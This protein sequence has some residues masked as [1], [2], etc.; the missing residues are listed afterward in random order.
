MPCGGRRELSG[1]S[2][3][4]YYIFSGSLGS[5]IPVLLS[6]ANVQGGREVCCTYL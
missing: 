3:Q 5:L 1:T 6:T 4:C 2:F